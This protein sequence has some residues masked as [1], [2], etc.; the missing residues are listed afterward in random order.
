MARIERF[1]DALSVSV[2]A[3]LVSSIV[4]QNRLLEGVTAAK[5][6]AQK[7]GRIPW[8]LVLKPSGPVQ[9]TKTLLFAE[10]AGHAVDNWL[11]DVLRKCPFFGLDHDLGRHAWGRRK[12]GNPL[13]FP[14]A[15]RNPCD[16]DL[17]GN[18]R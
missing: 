7:L 9:V 5:T 14:R 16:V 15:H 11:C 6:R 3:A 17:L 18:A 8:G 2:I 12:I 13:Q 4:A 1:L 10:G